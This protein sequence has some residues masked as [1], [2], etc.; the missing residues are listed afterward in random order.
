MSRP[1]CFISQIAGERPMHGATDEIGFH[2][3]EQRL[4]ITDIHATVIHQMGLDPRKL[5]V[6][7][8]SDWPSTMAHR[9]RKSLHRAPNRG[10]NVSEA[11]RFHASLT[12]RPRLLCPH[13]P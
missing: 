9:S 3:V 5:E 7:G 10:R 2:A 6:P 13:F 1:A 12:L 4:Y 8:E 11:Y